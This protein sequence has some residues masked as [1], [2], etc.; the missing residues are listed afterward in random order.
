MKTNYKLLAGAYLDGP[1]AILCLQAGFI[2]RVKKRNSS[3]MDTH[4]V[5]NYKVLVFENS[6][7]K[8]K[9]VLDLSIEIVNYMKAEFLNSCLFKLQF[10]DMQYEHVVLHECLMVL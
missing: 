3:V 2:Q 10:Q 6:N 1:P 9:K 7:S 8:M 5:L 4:F